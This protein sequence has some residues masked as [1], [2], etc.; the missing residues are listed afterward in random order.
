[1][2]VASI[3]EDKDAARILGRLASAG[4]ALVATRSSNDRALPAAALVEA[5]RGS[6]RTV[7]QVDDPAEALDYARGLGR[8][9][10]VTGSLYLLAD[11]AGK[12]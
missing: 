11:L 2:V 7:A 3:L 5:G 12:P 10:L 1:M 4:D 8:P 9:V 6:F